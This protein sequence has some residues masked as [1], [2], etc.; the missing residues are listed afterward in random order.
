M[1]QTTEIKEENY[2]LIE[3]D[4]RLDTTTHAELDDKMNQL[5]ASG[6]K[7][8]VFNLEKMEYI[9]SS[10]LRV[11][12]SVLKKVNAT[13]GRFVLYGMQDGVAEIFQIS[14]FSSIFNIA[15]SKAEA[16][17]QF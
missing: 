9:S 13:G 16:L 5:M 3:L 2:Y 17:A 12:L 10:G 7:N 6:V 1:L 4:G 15:K 14:G 11:F 8:L